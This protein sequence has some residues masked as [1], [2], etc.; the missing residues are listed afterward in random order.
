MALTQFIRVSATIVDANNVQ[1]IATCY[2]MVD[3]SSSITAITAFY[4]TWLSNLDALV[5]G[6]IIAASWTV[7][8]GLPGGLKSSPVAGSSCMGTGILN[9]MA[10]GSI[11]RWGFAIPALSKG[12]T[13][14]SGG[15][16][17]I[18]NPSPGYTMYTFLLATGTT[19]E[20]SNAAAQTLSSFTESLLS[21]RKYSKQLAGLSVEV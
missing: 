6:Q 14:Q 2:A 16:F 15:K 12:S 1:A 20:W 4:D 10:T 11:N 5:D 21:F 13:V 9:F 18:T 7:L 8:P 19:L 3:P 17:V